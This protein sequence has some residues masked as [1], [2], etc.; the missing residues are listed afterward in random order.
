MSPSNLKKPCQ[1]GQ[2]SER[3]AARF[4][5][6]RNSF[7]LA[8]MAMT[9]ASVSGAMGQ[10]VPRTVLP[11]SGWDEAVPFALAATAKGQIAAPSA[12]G[13]EGEKGEYSGF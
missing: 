1:S 6:F 13:T 3:T 12:E 11:R 8:G 5:V 4:V 9:S 7:D 2:R 10:V